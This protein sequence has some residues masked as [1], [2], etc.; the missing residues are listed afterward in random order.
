MGSLPLTSYGYLPQLLTF[1][2]AACVPTSF[3]NTFAALAHASPNLSGLIGGS[4]SY[5]DWESARNTLASRY[6][7]TSADWSPVGSPASLVVEGTQQY[8]A[9]RNVAQWLEIR[10]IGP[11]PGPEDPLAGLA[12]FNKNEDISVD[13]PSSLGKRKISRVSTPSY[14]SLERQ[15]LYEARTVTINDIANALDSGKGIILGL[16]YTSGGQGHAVSAVSLKWNDKNNNGRADRSEKATLSIVDPLDPSGTYSPALESDIAEERLRYNPLVQ[17]TGPVKSVDVHL[18]SE[19]D[20]T[21]Y[22]EYKQTS[23]KD[24][25]GKLIREVGDSSNDRTNPIE[26][27]TVVFAGFLKARDTVKDKIT[28]SSSDDV[29]ELDPGRDRI[30]GGDGSDLFVVGDALSLKKDNSD[31]ITDFKPGDNDIIGL[32][33]EELGIEGMQLEQVYSRRDL[34][35]A[36]RGEAELIYLETKR[37]GILYSNENGSRTGLGSGGGELIRLSGSPDLTN[38]SIALL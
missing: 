37:Y 30:K 34:R 32:R 22:W 10:A 29:I 2:E 18:W 21:V 12:N 24:K 23:I 16:I 8:A 14:D 4:G 27:G 33:S 36:A 5:A 7:F 3:I 11:G 28:G 19:D 35:M 1:D 38:E 25:D 15:R 17:A 9:D 6:F 31:I 20:G 26:T 13:A